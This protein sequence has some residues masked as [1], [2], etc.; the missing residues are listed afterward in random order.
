MNKKIASELAIGAILLLVIFF[1]WIFLTQNKE[2]KTTNKIQNAETIKPIELD[3][4][5][6]EVDL[7]AGFEKDPCKGHLYEGEVDLRGRYVLDVAYGDEEQ[8][9]FSVV[10]ED[11]M[12]LPIQIKVGDGKNVNELLKIEDATAELITKLKKATDENPETISIKGYYLHCE[13]GPI[14]SIQNPKLALAKYLKR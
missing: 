7:T 13:G 12:K 10:K 9:Y 3:E 8:W 4:K 1:S 11:L 2:Q 14:V 6:E 5:K